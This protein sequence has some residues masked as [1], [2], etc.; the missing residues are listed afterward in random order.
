MVDAGVKLLDL[1]DDQIFA[2]LGN[3][4]YPVAWFRLAPG[5][6]VI[7]T[8]AELTRRGREW[9]EKLTPALKKKICIEWG[10][11]GK[12]NKYKSTRELIQVITPLVG[13]AIGI[14][15]TVAGVAV[16]VTTIL[17]RMG[18]DAFCECK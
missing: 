12:K 10:Y 5:R 8:T 11:C 16:T 9:F 4:V 13:S 18:L 3:Q 14:S 1:P 15:A 6:E 7:S 17:V 2:I